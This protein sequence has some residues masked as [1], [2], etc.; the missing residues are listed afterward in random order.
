[1]R[2]ETRG[3]TRLIRDGRTCFQPEP[4]GI[5]RAIRAR[6]EW[7]HV[8]ALCAFAAVLRVQPV[9][10]QQ[11]PSFRVAFYNVQSGLGEPGLSSRH[12]LFT[13]DANCADPTRPLNAWGVGFVQQHL[14]TALADPTVVAL[15]LAEAWACASPS[16]IRRTLGWTSNTTERN[17]TAVVAR[18]GFSG[19]EEWV[20]LDTS[21]NHNPGDTM[22][23]LR[24][25]VC[26]DPSCSA[27]I[28]LFTTHWFAEATATISMATMRESYD[29]QAAG[30]SAFLQRTANGS[31]VLIG[32]LN[33]WEGSAPVCGQDPVNAG[34]NRLR[35]AGYV[36]AWPLIHGSAEGFTGMTNRPRCG[37]PEGYVWKRPDYMW[38]PSY[39]LPKSISRFGIVP[40]GEAAP[41][42]HY[43]LLA[44]F[45]WPTPAQ[46]P[47]PGSLG[48]EEIVLHAHNASIV[49][50]NWRVTADGT[51]AGGA[52]LW[53]PDGGADKLSVPPSPTANYFELSFTADA[54][55]AYRL[56][57]RGQAEKNEWV[58]DSV[59][60]QFSGSVDH[61]GTPIWRIGTKNA[62][63]VSMEE[64]S[65][66]GLAGWGW[67][68]NGYDSPGPLLYFASSGPQTLRIQQREDGMSI[69]QIV[70]SPALFLQNAPGASKN[71]TTLYTASNLTSRPPLT[72]SV[73]EVVLY[74]ASA[75]RIEGGWQRQSDPTA[76][77]GNRLWNPDVG[78]A[79]FR[80]AAETPTTYFELTFN[81]DASRGYRLWIRGQ[82]QA[83]YWTNDS[84]FVQ[85]SGS[86]DQTGAP[87]FRI[88]TTE[89]TVVSVEEG[90]GLELAGWGWQDNGY[91]SVGPLVY[92][93][94][95]GPQTIRIQQ[96]EDG[97]SIDQIVLSA[98]AYVTTAPGGPKNDTTIL[99]V[100]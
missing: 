47:P 100:R 48:A 82:A 36:D 4:I 61:Y 96:R 28:D 6:R 25:P 18:Y 21:L 80:D 76:A 58:N 42:D 69:D 10:A 54:G 40:A 24:I 91:A 72:S 66:M 32:D 34:L 29:R 53:N 95:S 88:G 5:S 7:R 60:V 71:D 45:P 37:I 70:L 63:V 59:F 74:A 78:A 51:A 26:L 93:A 73:D 44:E 15:G 52:R 86:V 67:Q 17:G 33:T 43:G 62:T 79:K 92:F 3:A 50:G 19:A 12:V 46:S 99:A 85:F 83:D 55:R 77:G 75:I 30:T 22:W 11:A 81:A 90:S 56:W 97:I 23:V 2:H 68:D 84:V 87:V 38:S 64:G 14:R 9:H 16:N 98:S 20:Q 41:S 1:M 49:A 94:S 65:G 39:L 57:V 89:A 13:K 27:S 35:D 8:A 31:H